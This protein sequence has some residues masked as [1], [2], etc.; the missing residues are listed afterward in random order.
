MF[1]ILAQLLISQTLYSK[2]SNRL[3]PV[4]V[5]S[6]IVGVAFVVSMPVYILFG[7]LMSSVF[8]V[9]KYMGTPPMGSRRC[10]YTRMRRYC[11]HTSRP[12]H[13]FQHN[14]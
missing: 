3:L 12:H 7:K 6:L 14:Y 9:G 11:N 13:Y 5:S 2:E 8:L 1:V 4:G 10:S